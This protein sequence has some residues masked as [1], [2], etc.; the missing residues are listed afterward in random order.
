MAKKLYILDTNVLISDPDAVNA[1]DD[2]TVIIPTEVIEELD[3]QKNEPG[4]KGFNV[5]RAIRNIHALQENGKLSEGVPVGNGG[6]LRI[7]GTKLSVSADRDLFDAD[8]VD[9]AILRLAQDISVN[10]L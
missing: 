8:K 9:N 6:E 1:F 10:G 5:R 2:N 7:Y 3:N 4:D